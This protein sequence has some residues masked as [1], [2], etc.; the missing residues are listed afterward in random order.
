MKNKALILLIIILSFHQLCA[1]SLDLRILEHI[2]G[3]VNPRPDRF[4]NSVSNQ[5]YKIDIAVPLSLF[6][7]G[8]I[9]HDQSLKVK[10]YETGAA[11]IGAGG[12][13]YILKKVVKR[14]RPATIYPGII[15]PKVNET[16]YSFPSG[17]AS[18]AFATATSISLAFPKWYVIIPSFVYAGAVSYSR[19]YLGVHYPSDI[20]G[21]VIIGIA[22]SY[23][24]FQAQKLIILRK[25]H[26]KYINE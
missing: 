16:D 7:I 19:L 3:E 25:Q 20:I 22:S 8:L 1:Q 4:W 12:V 26:R 9:K 13:T 2:N 17:H 24:T 11:L 23:I 21:G 18:F 10:A 15:I 6:T 5:S 14:E